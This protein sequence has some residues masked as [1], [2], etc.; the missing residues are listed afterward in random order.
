MMPLSTSAQQ[1]CQHMPTVSDF[2]NQMPD[3]SMLLETSMESFCLFVGVAGSW[4]MQRNVSS[5]PR[6][7]LVSSGQVLLN[8]MLGS[9]SGS[10]HSCSSAASRRAW[11]GG[12]ARSGSWRRTFPRTTGVGGGEHAL[13]KQQGTSCVCIVHIVA[14]LCDKA[15]AGL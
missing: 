1:T 9:E 8:T 5:G 11:T 6:W 13:Q 15:C 3:Y 12:L 2:C 10:W 4:P 7:R 14:H